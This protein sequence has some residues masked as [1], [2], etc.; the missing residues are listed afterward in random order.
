MCKQES[1][2]SGSDPSSKHLTHVWMSRDL[3]HSTL[4]ELTLFVFGAVSKQAMPPVVRQLE[5]LCWELLNLGFSLQAQLICPQRLPFQLSIRTI[6][7]LIRSVCLV[8][9]LLLAEPDFKIWFK[10]IFK[11]NHRYN[12]KLPSV[13]CRRIKAHL[14]VLFVFIVNSIYNVQPAPFSF[15]L[16]SML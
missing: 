5:E 11:K 2:H 1:E 13:F 6:E 14:N 15:F 3:L 16:I 8:F 9:R 12:F 10:T 4:M 7:L